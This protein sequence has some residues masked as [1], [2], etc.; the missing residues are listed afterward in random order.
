MIK[1][2]LTPENVKIYD[3]A[4]DRCVRGER[5]GIPRRFLDECA[6]SRPLW[7]SSTSGCPINSRPGGPEDCSHRGCQGGSACRVRE[8]CFQGRRHNFSTGAQGTAKAG[9][10]GWQAYV[11]GAAQS[12]KLGGKLGGQGSQKHAAIEAVKAGTP[13]ASG[14][15]A[16]KAGAHV[17]SGGAS[18][19]SAMM[20]ASSG[21]NKSSAS[22]WAERETTAKIALTK[23][24]ALGV[25]NT[26]AARAIEALVHPI[27]THSHECMDP[28]CRRPVKLIARYSNGKMYSNFGHWCLAKKNIDGLAK[29]LCSTCHQTSKI[30]SVLT[31][32][33][34]DVACTSYHARRLSY[35]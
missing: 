34:I 26:G 11:E 30:G 25:K 4:I 31:Q 16:A 6:T 28:E 13:A 33:K 9:K 23:G 1:P 3:A 35:R 10:T 32:R 24:R 14:N 12:R 27:A 18:K 22:T 15:S 2:T 5:H 19:Q 8:Q 29:H 7:R 17:D 20:W 21:G